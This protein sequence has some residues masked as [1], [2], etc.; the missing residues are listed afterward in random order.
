MEKMELPCISTIP[1]FDK[2]FR[3]II[4]VTDTPDYFGIIDWINTHSKDLVDVKLVHNRIGHLE[5]YFAFVDPDDALIFKI[6]FS[7]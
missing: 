5:M 7:I 2:K 4:K 3:I 1:S 6:K